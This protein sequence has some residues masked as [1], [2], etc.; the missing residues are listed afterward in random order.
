MFNYAAIARLRRRG[1]TP[2]FEFASIRQNI[3]RHPRWRMSFT[4]DGFSAVGVTLQ[5]VLEEAYNLYD[6]KRWS[7]TP[8][9][10]SERRFNI[11]A[12]YDQ[13]E[14]KDRT[15]AQSRAMLQ[16]LLVDRF[17]L[18]VHH[19]PKER[20]IYELVVARHTPKLVAAKQDRN[21]DAIYRSTCR[22]THDTQ[23]HLQMADCTV[24]NLISVLAPMAASDLNRQ[25]IDGTGLTGHYDFDLSWTPEDPAAAALI[26]SG[27]PTIFT[28]VKKE[29]G[30]ELKP[31][32]GVVDTIVIDKIEM[33]SPN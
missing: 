24:N 15:G 3:D 33:P 14:H 29:L 1:E 2:T 27:A 21:P 25:I 7:G 19:E 16:Q 13:A 8:K 30:L 11:E 23:D 9:W 6:P 32:E 26:D 22:I 12:R 17:G 4:I 31:T 5:N 20:P 28:A 10:I 18:I